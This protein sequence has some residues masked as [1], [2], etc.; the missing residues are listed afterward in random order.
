MEQLTGK[1]FPGRFERLLGAPIDQI[2]AGL[3]VKIAAS[4]KS[5]GGKKEEKVTKKLLIRLFKEV[6]KEGCPLNHAPTPT[7]EPELEAPVAGAELHG[8]GE[9][10]PTHFAT[11]HTAYSLGGVPLTV[12]RHRLCVDGARA[13]LGGLCGCVDGCC[14]THTASVS[15]R[16]RTVSA[17]CVYYV[18]YTPHI[19]YASRSA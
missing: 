9:T 17:V 14:G 6:V 1:R 4:G 7:P 10:Q 2:D 19:A 15:C 8:G 18:P 12:V 3:R 13:L 16:H 5:L 11:L